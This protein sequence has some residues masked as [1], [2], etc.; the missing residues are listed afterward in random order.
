MRVLLKNKKNDAYMLTLKERKFCEEYVVL[1]NATAAALRAGYTPITAQ[2]HSYR[3][4]KDTREESSRPKM[5]DYVQQLRK[6]L[7]EEFTISK[8]KVLFGM[9]ALALFD[10]AKLYDATGKPIPIHLLDEVSRMGIQGFEYD[11]KGKLK[12]YKA[13][14]RNAAWSNLAKLLGYNSPE[15]LKHD[16]GETFLDFLRGTGQFSEEKEVH[17]DTVQNEKTDLLNESE[18]M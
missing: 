16:A 9:V 6:R 7:E 15:K 11:R 8:G 5:W 18:S 1:G 4:V 17:V 12:R 13:A 3:W 10:P 14:D 2:K